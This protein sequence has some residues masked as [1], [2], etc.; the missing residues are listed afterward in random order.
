[1][2]LFSAMKVMELKIFITSGPKTTLIEVQWKGMHYARIMTTSYLNRQN[3]WQD[4]HK[5]EGK[6]PAQSPS[7]G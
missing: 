5:N 7:H 6:E 2:Q 1:M 4:P 3:I